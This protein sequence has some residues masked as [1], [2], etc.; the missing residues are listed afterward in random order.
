MVF[1]V[2]VYCTRFRLS[3]LPTVAV[4]PFPSPYPPYVRGVPVS[5]ALSS[6]RSLCTRFRRSILLAIA[7]YPFCHCFL[8]LTLPLRN[9][10]CS[11]AYNRNVLCLPSP[12]LYMIL[13]L[14]YRPLTV[15]PLNDGCRRLVPCAT[16]VLFFRR[17]RT[18]SRC[19]SS[20]AAT[21]PATRAPRAV[22][23]ARTTSTSEGL[24][25]NYSAQQHLVHT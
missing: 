4:Y 14:W 10:A 20:G 13:L 8:S 1:A 24:D 3:I 17:E 23:E 16:F 6:L 9:A 25:R 5:I 18:A 19:S 11:A 21:T 22:G 7:V 15:P 12:L 2:A